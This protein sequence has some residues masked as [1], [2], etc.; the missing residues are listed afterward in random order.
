MFPYYFLSIITT[1]H[2]TLFNGELM[3]SPWWTLYSNYFIVTS[4]MQLFLK[5]KPLWLKI[6]FSFI[7]RYFDFTIALVFSLVFLGINVSRIHYLG[8]GYQ[9]LS[10]LRST[11]VFTLTGRRYSGGRS[12]RITVS[13]A[14]KRRT[15]GQ[16][17]RVHRRDSASVASCSPD[18]LQSC[19]HVRLVEHDFIVPDI[20]RGEE[21]RQSCGLGSTISP[22]WHLNSN[23]TSNFF[24]SSPCFYF[25]SV[26]LLRYFAHIQ[27]CCLF[28]LLSVA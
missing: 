9:A 6:L 23:K 27:I 13:C 22:T 24:N 4:L 12:T 7:P 19:E 1:S 11:R 14:L 5:N 21:R 2:F 3:S 26:N 28:V 16:S 15:I 10:R 25:F 18:S 17:E 20:K 8:H